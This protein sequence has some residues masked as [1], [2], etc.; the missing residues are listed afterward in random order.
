MD[1]IRGV[2][3]EFGSEDFTIDTGTAAARLV[4]NATRRLAQESNYRSIANSTVDSPAPDVTKP[5]EK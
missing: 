3:Q 5:P 2:E 1:V 4:R